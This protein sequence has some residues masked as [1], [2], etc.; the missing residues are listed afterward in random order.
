[1]EEEM[2][3]VFVEAFDLGD[4]WFRCLSRILDVGH[5]YEVTCGSFVGQ[6]RLEF[7]FAVVHVKKPSHRPIIPLV[8]EG[9]PVPAPTSMEYVERY[10]SYL[11]TGHRAVGENYTYGERL[12]DPKIVI[13]EAAADA[14]TM[15]REMPLH[16]NQIQETIEIYRKS[17]YG[18]NQ[19][20]MEIGMPSD[21]KLKDPPCLRLID[22]RVRYGKLHFV[23]YFRSWDLW[24]GFPANLA[25]LQL[26]KEYMAEE[27]GVGDGEIIAVSKGLHLYEH[28]WELARMR[29]GRIEQGTTGRGPKA[30]DGVC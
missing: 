14:D 7:D 28:C 9:C 24:A 19:A 30:Q 21:I 8:P 18:T 15:I 5:C 11:L 20:T 26:L 2:R 1:M 13:K 25:A 12:V 23:L 3:P 10:M 6:R 17:G 16:V 4:A 22:T 27:I 29:T